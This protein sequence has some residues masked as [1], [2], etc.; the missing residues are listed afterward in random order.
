MGWGS[1]EFDVLD[2]VQDLIDKDIY[3]RKKARIR[4]MKKDKSGYQSRRIMVKLMNA[5]LAHEFH[6]SESNRDVEM[7]FNHHRR[8]V[9]DFGKTCVLSDGREFDKV[10]MVTFKKYCKF[11]RKHTSHKETK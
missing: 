10:S 5:V 4:L 6:Y 7:V 2:E 1:D 8:N 9:A 3:R 11:C